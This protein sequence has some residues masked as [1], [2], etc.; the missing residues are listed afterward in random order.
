MGVRTSNV[1]GDGMSVEQAAG[2][3]V[4]ARTVKVNDTGLRVEESGAGRAVVVLSPPLYA[5]K[6]IFDAPMVALGRDH[7]CIRYDH[8]GHGESGLGAPDSPERLGVEGLCDDALALLD[9]LDVEE[10]HW[11]GVSLGSLVGL[12]LAARHPERIRS[13]TM[14]GL[15]TGGLTRAELRRVAILTTAVRA[16]RWLGP[17]GTTVR[18]AIV[19]QLMDGLLGPTFMADPSRQADRDLWRQ[20]FMRTV[21]PEAV[22]MLR[23][24]YGHAA[25]PP[26]LLAVVDAPTLVVAGEEELAEVRADAAEAQRLIHGARSVTIPGAGHMVLIEQPDVGTAVIQAFIEEVEAG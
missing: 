22:P 6:E 7:R 13:L 24:L 11:V 16:T 3:A 21:V 15:S 18:R 23:Q 1:I 17:V 26:E 9:E 14:I 4:R 5:N 10:C 20:R 25:T 19:G 2:E 12:R 8:R